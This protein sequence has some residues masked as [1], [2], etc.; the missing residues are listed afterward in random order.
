MPI[1]KRHAASRTD[2]VPHTVYRMTEK[3]SGYEGSESGQIRSAND[4]IT[5][6][7]HVDCFGSARDGNSQ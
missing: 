3:K 4:E 5:K 6:T 7:I 2:S 1:P